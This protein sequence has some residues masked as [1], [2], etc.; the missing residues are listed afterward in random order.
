MEDATGFDLVVDDSPIGLTGEL[1]HERDGDDRIEHAVLVAHEV[2][3]AEVVAVIRDQNDE[4][5]VEHPGPFE[6]REQLPET[7]VHRP[8]VGVVQ[9]SELSDT[10]RVERIVPEEMGPFVRGD[11][12]RPELLVDERLEQGSAGERGRWA[13][14]RLQKRKN[15][16]C[17]RSSTDSTRSDNP[18][19][20]WP[21]APVTLGSVSVYTALK[22]RSTGR[23][24]AAVLVTVLTSGAAA[25]T[26]D[27]GTVT[28]DSV[29]NSSNPRPNP[30]LGLT[31]SLGETAYVSYP[32]SLSAS[33]S[34]GLASSIG[35]IVVAP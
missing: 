19:G 22:S 2:E 3:L 18:S 5:V 13:S 25:S 4:R 35:R 6:R 9:L 24:T 10:G 16:S 23:R 14:L 17:A 7:L 11:G 33:G 1:D 30:V 8:Q 28:P 26:T 31:Y 32:A 34:V 21:R 29:W 20:S 27:W 12:R 15:G